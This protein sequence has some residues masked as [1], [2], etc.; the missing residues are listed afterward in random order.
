MIAVDTGNSTGSAARPKAPPT[1][2]EAE[3]S[4][5]C[6][7]RPAMNLLVAQA[8]QSD[9]ERPR[10]GGL[11]R[12]GDNRRRR[13]RQCPRYQC[14]RPSGERRHLAGKSRLL[15]PLYRRRQRNTIHIRE[16]HAPPAGRDRPAMQD[17][18]RA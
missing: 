8:E 18:G 16:I 12:F 10:Q 15:K 13:A 9:V 5:E 6:T 11:R 7:T 4:A 1:A 17:I 3:A 2:P 14:R